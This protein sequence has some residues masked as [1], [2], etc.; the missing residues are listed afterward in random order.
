MLYKQYDINQSFILL[1]ILQASKR[2]SLRFFEH[3][4]KGVFLI[5]LT[6]GFKQ[7]FSVFVRGSEFLLLVD[8]LYLFLNILRLFD[9]TSGVSEAT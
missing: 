6:N 2:N 5:G 1:L 4:V 7:R 9:S 3:K 8:S